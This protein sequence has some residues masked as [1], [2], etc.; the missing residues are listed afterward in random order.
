MPAIIGR[1]SVAAPLAEALEPLRSEPSRAAILLDVDGT[2]AP[3]VRHA[4]D[5]HVPEPTRVPLI[6]VAKRYG[7]VACVSGRQAAIARRI[8]SLGTITYV[9]NHGAEILRG[10][11][12]EVEHDPEIAGWGRRV[13]DFARGAMTDELR[14]LRV[15]EEDKQVIAAL[16]WRGAPDEAAAEAAVM[17][18]GA[19]AQAAGFWTHRG[20][21][22]LEIR[23]PVALDKG[24]GIT[25]LLAGQDLDAA[26]YVGDDLTD[27]DAFAALRTLRDDGALTTALCVGVASDETPPALAESA[28]LLVDGPA[29]VRVLLSTLA[30]SRH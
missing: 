4:D 21:K 29:G 1:V 13:Q 14:R 28:D 23:P 26:L 27:L 8:V 17:A 10:G 24:R 12:T 11:A 3:I 20:R 5:A 18:V 15:R 7:L 30:A 19:E 2:L 6:A 25:R 16:H 22:V 9:G